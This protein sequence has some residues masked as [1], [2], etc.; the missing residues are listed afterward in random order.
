MKP[1]NVCTPRLALSG[2]GALALA[3]LS[4]ATAGPVR[5][6]GTCIQDKADKSLV[7]TANDVRIASAENIRDLRGNP[8][9]SCISGQTFSFIA[10][11]RVQTGATAR[12]DVGL[13]FATDGDP[14]YDGARSGVCGVN[15]ID[16]K[17]TTTGLGSVNYVNLDGD[18]CGDINTSHNPQ[19]V[20]V[21][22]DNVVCQDSDADGL[23]NLPNCTSW[24][25]NS[26]NICNTAD[27]TVPGS[28]SKC[29]CDIA[30]NIAIRVE[31]G[32]IGVTK[33]ASPA[34]L[35]EPGGEFTFTVGATNSAQ[36][37]S[38]ALDRICDN[39]YGT[40]KKV[41]TA[42]DCTAGSL[43]TINSTDC[44]LPQTLGPGDSY[45]CSFKGNVTSN[46]GPLTGVTDVVTVFGHDSNSPPRAVQ[47][48]D[49]AQVAVTDV[50]PTASVVKTFVDLACADVHYRVRVNSSDYAESLQLTALSDSGF[51]SLT[52]VHDNVLSTTCSVPRTIAAGDYYECDFRAHFCGESH[53]N[54]VTATLND[55][56]NNVVSPDS[57]S[58]QVDVNAAL[59]DPQP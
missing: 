18:G 29:A 40:V 16:P 20:S 25:Q 57:N 47:G 33:D 53:T 43:G 7:C 5:A 4:L 34:S 49:S 2:I 24:A 23:L 42:A 31:L 1:M 3:A 22:V 58:L 48:S 52:S 45:S 59:H 46:G 38:V 44:S 30:F 36:F 39:H 51:G 21:R 17:D 56:E 12:Y 54:K 37:T 13:F 15:R 32:T 10:D 19:I 11:F 50:A 6:A 28:P 14:N 8:I 9:S 26:G 41:A 35:P 55:V 27:N